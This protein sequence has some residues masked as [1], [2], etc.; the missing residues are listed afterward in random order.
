MAKEIKF[1]DEELQSLN[2]LSQGYQNVQAAF[3][4]MKVQH[5]LA[6]QQISSLEE[7]EVQMESDYSDLQEKER[8]L[9]QQLNEKYGPGQLDPQ[10]GVFTPA[11]EPEEQE[12]P[13]QEDDSAKA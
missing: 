13:A 1:S 8:E 3:G 5:I 10:T 2:E 11:P 12:V 4:Q 7:A 9:V 6:E